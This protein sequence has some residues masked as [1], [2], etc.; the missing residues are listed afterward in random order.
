MYFTHPQFKK[1][2]LRLLFRKF[3]EADFNN[4]LANLFPSHNIILTDS[5]RSAFQIAIKELGLE[6]SEMILPAYI[7]DIF[8]PIL[9]HFEIKPIYLDTDIETFHMDLSN[10]ESLITPNTK[11]ILICHTYG[12]PVQMEEISRIARNHNL[13]V[14]ED[15]AHIWPSKINGDC[16]FFSFT[17]FFPVIDGGMLISKETIN[18]NLEKYQSK[19]FNTIRF[20]RLFPFVAKLSE[21]FRQERELIERRW[22][23]P[24]KISQNSLK[25]V[26]YYLGNFEEQIKNRIKLGKYFQNKLLGLKLKVQNGQD[27]TFTYLSALVPEN[28]NRDDL[29]S[30]LRKHNI[31]CSRVWQNPLFKQLPN[32]SIVSKR[33]I[34]FPLQNWYIEKDIDKIISCILS[35]IGSTT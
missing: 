11:S 7:C 10:I 24:R 15:C 13:K 28:I 25:I 1:F 32:T 6:N 19:L 18:T 30:K 33:I 20:L 26:N 9:K 31:F 5:G 2:P 4:K 35:D 14:I 3:S 16:A 23:I 22:S 21:K 27:N 17:K 8:K 29:F 12:L 34:N